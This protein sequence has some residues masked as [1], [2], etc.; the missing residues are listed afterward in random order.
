M[1]HRSAPL[2]AFCAFVTAAHAEEFHNPART[3]RTFGTRGAPLTYIVLGDSTAAGQ[4]GN[5]EQGIAVSTARELAKTHAV[6]MTNLA[7]SGA[8]TGDVLRDQ[9]DAAARLHPDLVL[10]SVG[11]NDITHLT[12]VRSMRRHLTAIL[13]R[14]RAANPNVAIVLTGSPDMG[15][16]PRIPRPLRPIAAWRT[17]RTN[18]MFVAVARAQQVTFARIAETTGPLFRAD[19]TLFA[20]DLFHPND[21]GYATWMPEL[22]RALE[23]ALRGR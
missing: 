7:V 20:S 1:P 10:I 15:A 6:T 16:P 11:A 2:L 17:R 23:E 18:E 21:R 12:C 22:N 9:V 8:K 13:A 4:G 3:P 19:P 14:L 5:Y